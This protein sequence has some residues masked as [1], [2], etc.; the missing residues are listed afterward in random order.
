M[1]RRIVI[2]V[3][4]LIVIAGVSVGVSAASSPATTSDGVTTSASGAR[5]LRLV[6]FQ[7]WKTSVPVPRQNPN[8]DRLPGDQQLMVQNVKSR[9]TGNLVAHALIH[10][11]MFRKDSLCE[12]TF[13]F[14]NGQIT[15]AGKVPMDTNTHP[16]IVPVTGG[17]GPFQNARGQVV[18]NNSS[19]R[20]STNETIY[21]LP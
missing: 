18:I 6:G 19:T 2:P 12:I 21:L 3:A 8:Q 11:Q 9:A 5:V 15:G 14:P 1:L 16:F 10:C 7:A 20:N 4:A 13:V 17:S